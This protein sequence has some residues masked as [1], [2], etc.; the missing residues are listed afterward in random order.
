MEISKLLARKRWLPAVIWAG[1]IMAGSSFPGSLMKPKLFPGCDK[2]AHFIEY[3]LLGTAVRYWTREFNMLAICGGV[4][5]GAMDE[6]H[7]YFVPGRNAS[8]L[9]LGADIAGF[10]IGYIFI[11]QRS[12]NGRKD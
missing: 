3:L 12:R 10:F 5:F 9:D 6:F 8:V 11:K 2:V 1:L 7:Q 4:A